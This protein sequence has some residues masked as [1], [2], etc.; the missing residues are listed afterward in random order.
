M[1]ILEDFLHNN[2]QHLPNDTTNTLVGAQSQNNAHHKHHLHTTWT[3]SAMHGQ[4][5]PL[6]VPKNSAAPKQA[7]AQNCLPSRQ[8]NAADFLAGNTPG[9]MAFYAPEEQRL[10]TQ[11]PCPQPANI[12]ANTRPDNAAVEDAETVARLVSWREEASY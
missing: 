9:V 11:H 2:L 12:H 5:N 8:K 3:H 7:S 6:P 1:S 10:A 4:Q